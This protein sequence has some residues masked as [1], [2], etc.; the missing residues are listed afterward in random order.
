M[1]LVK[2]VTRRIVYTLVCAKCHAGWES[3]VAVGKCPH[4]GRPAQRPSENVAKKGKSA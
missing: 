3:E 2:T 4:C 1:E